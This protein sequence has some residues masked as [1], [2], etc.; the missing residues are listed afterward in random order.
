MNTQTRMKAGKED[1]V[2]GAESVDGG[3]MKIRANK[4]TSTSSVP[5]ASKDQRRRTKEA[6][7]RE[8]LEADQG[9]IPSLTEIEY[10]NAV[11]SAE[12]ELAGANEKTRKLAEENLD[13]ACVTL[14]EKLQKRTAETTEQEPKGEVTE[15]SS[16][17]EEFVTDSD[18]DKCGEDMIVSEDEDSDADYLSPRSRCGKKKVLTNWDDSSDD[19]EDVEMESRSEKSDESATASREANGIWLAGVRINRKKVKAKVPR[20]LKEPEATTKANPPPV[21]PSPSKDLKPG[22][23]VNNC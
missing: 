18:E 13:V 17:E 22:S 15:V 19:S 11:I 8:L 6:R 7:L 16:G 9:G 2:K 12:T 21:T 4:G 5:N 1:M 20:T 10:A 14:A 23:K 3:E